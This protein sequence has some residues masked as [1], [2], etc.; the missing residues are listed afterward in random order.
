MSEH[1]PDLDELE[2]LAKA[3][4]P[5]PWRKGRFDSVVDGEGFLVAGD[6]PDHDFIAACQP[7]AILALIEEV[8]RLRVIELDASLAAENEHFR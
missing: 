8:R 3:A 1:M 4:T 5:G 7:Q 2:R 6:C